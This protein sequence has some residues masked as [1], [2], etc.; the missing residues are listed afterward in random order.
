MLKAALVTAESLP[1]PAA[2]A[3]LLAAALEA[4]GFEA[5][6]PAW[7]CQETAW[8][9]FDLVLVG[10]AWDYHTRVDEFLAWADRVNNA[11][12]VLNAPSFLHWNARKTYLNQLAGAGIHVIPTLKVGPD[13]RYNLARLSRYLDCEDLIM[14]PVVGAGASGLLRLEVSQESLFQE[15]KASGEFLV[16]P[17]IPS[18]HEGEVSLTMIDGKLSHA[19]RKVAREGDFRVQ[20]E[21]GGT[22][23][24][25]EASEDEQE[26]AGIAMWVL[27]SMPL[28]ARVDMIEFKGRPALMELELIE[29]DLHLRHQP[30]SA[31]ALAKAAKARLQ[32]RQP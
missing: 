26:L 21:H 18:I 17:F 23:I 15:A 30:E 9:E 27:P 22:I 29:P 24:Q 25:H 10:S 28:Y 6:T 12:T 7:S 13:S 2:D 4:E 20:E 8:E 14:K 31:S 16:Q 1:I 5:A 11:T 19:V 3:P 32:N